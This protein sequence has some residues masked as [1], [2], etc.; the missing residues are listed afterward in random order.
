MNFIASILLVAGT[1]AAVS[2]AIFAG[3]A[4]SVQHI[5]PIL[6]GVTAL[7]IGIVLLA[8]YSRIGRRP[9]SSSH[10]H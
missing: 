9:A 8:I 1:V 4:L 10:D 7:V 3:H 6:L 5:E 2:F